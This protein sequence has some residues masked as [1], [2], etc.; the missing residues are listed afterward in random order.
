MISEGTFSVNL[1]KSFGSLI[2]GVLVDEHWLYAPEMQLLS[3]EDWKKAYNAYN[4][5]YL[6]NC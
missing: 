6:I 4:N 1:R 2:W 5:S 3:L